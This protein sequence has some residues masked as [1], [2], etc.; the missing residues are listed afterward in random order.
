MCGRFTHKFTWQELHDLL[1]RGQWPAR[2]A[3]A[4]SEQ[5]FA[6]NYNVAPTQNAP[7]IRAIE[8]PAPASTGAIAGLEVAFLRWGLAPHWSTDPKRGPINARAETVATNGMFRSAFKS[9][10]A[11]VPVSGFYEWMPAAS[12][13]SPKQ[14]MYIT[15]ADAQPLL[16]AGLWERWGLAANHADAAHRLETFTIITTSANAFM[17]SVHDR[18]PVI[19]EPESLSRWLEPQANPAALQTLLRP[20]ADGILQMHPV[21]TKV[22]S[23]RNTGAELI[24]R[25]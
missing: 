17:A 16:L 20:A 24:Q 6:S 7:V 10:R 1:S 5:L 22:N 13:G 21:S 2:L 8:S 14:P 18:M 9:R 15:R 19:L 23:P 3:A 4:N 25:V 11:V 12:E